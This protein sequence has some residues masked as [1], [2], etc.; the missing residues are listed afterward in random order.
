[1]KAREGRGQR[2]KAAS[3]ETAQ[4]AGRSVQYLPSSQTDKE[5]IARGIAAAGQIRHGPV[6]VLS[7][8]GP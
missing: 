4:I 1:M 5:K 7:C 6:C 2:L 8:V 3:P